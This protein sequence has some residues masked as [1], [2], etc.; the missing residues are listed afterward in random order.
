MSKYLPL[1][2]FA[3]PIMNQYRSEVELVD[4][5]TRLVNKYRAERVVTKHVPSFTRGVVKEELF[6]EVGIT[7][8]SRHT[9]TPVQFM[10]LEERPI[11]MF[12][13]SVRECVID[14]VV[15]VTRLS[16]YPNSMGFTEAKSVDF[17]VGGQQYAISNLANMLMSLR[18]LVKMN[19]LQR[20]STHINDNQYQNVIFGLKI[21]INLLFSLLSNDEMQA[22]I[23]HNNQVMNEQVKRLQEK[24][25]KIIAVNVDEI[26]MVMPED[27]DLGKL[28]GLMDCRFM[29][30]NAGRCIFMHEGKYITNIQGQFVGFWKERKSC[31]PTN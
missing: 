5:F 2:K 28:Y 13:K 20:P 15:C 30:E 16:A 27:L 23:S 7:T 11:R 1:H 12:D 25:C 31:L 9:D 10:N 21:I 17:E 3:F 14:N 18:S 29:A 24:G 26:Y 4:A 8:H 22:V 19:N 6:A